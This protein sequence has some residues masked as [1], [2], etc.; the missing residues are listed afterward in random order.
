MKNYK[1]SRKWFYFSLYFMLFI[2]S[3][4]AFIISIKDYKTWTYPCLFLLFSISS[5]ISSYKEFKLQRS[6]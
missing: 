6:E 3:T 4:I 5:L 1:K 2:A